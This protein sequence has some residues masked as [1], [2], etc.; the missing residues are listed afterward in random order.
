MYP[1]R[2]YSLRLVSLLASILIT[3]TGLYAA[4]KEY[5]VN[6]SATVSDTSPRITLSWTQQLQGNISAQRIYRR[7]KGETVWVKLADLTTTQTSYADTT[8]ASGVEY[9]YWLERTF[10]GTSPSPAIGYISA[11]VKVPEVH[12]RG[13]LLLV[14]D[15]TMVAPLAPE[16]AQLELDLAGD[17]WTVQQI[18]A[19]RSGTAISTKA[20]ITAA[21]NADPANVKMV[22]LLGHVPVPYSGNIGPDGHGDHVGAWP[23]DAYYGDMDDVWTDAT[24]NNTGASGTRNDNV[25]GDGKFD[26][27]NLPSLVELAVG[28]VDF[29]RINRAPSS[30]FSETARLRRYLRKAHDYRHKQGAYAAIPRRS[31]IRDGFGQFGS[32]AF[33]TTGW[34]VAYS[35]VG[36]SPGAPIDEPPSDQWFTPTYASGQ[37]YLWGYGCGGGSHESA[38]N[39]GNTTDF[40]HLASRAV[41]TSLFGSY[42]GD[43]DSDNNLMRSALAGNATG[44]SLALTCFWAGRPRYFMH[45]MGLGETVGFAAQTSMNAGLTGG[46]NYQPGGFSF[47]GTHLG[48]MGDPAL[49]VHQVTP[50]RRLAATTAS[51]QVNLSWAASG[52]TG[53]QGY[54]VYR[55]TS[56]G[57][58]FTKLN[59]LPV[60]ST[61]FTDA[62]VAAGTTY[63]YLVRT[64]RIEDAPGGTYHN[65]SIGSP[66]TITASAAGTGA[67]LSPSELRIVSQDSSISTQ[68]AWLDNASNETSYRVERKTNAGGTYATIGTL[69]VNVSTFTDTTA[70]TPGNVYYYRVIAVG[71]AG[72]SVPSNEV[73]FDAL[74]GFIEFTATRM[75]VDKLTGTAT[76]PVTRFGGGVGIVNVTYATANS[77][78]LAAQHYTSTN[79]TLTWADG[80]QGTKDITVSLIDSGT[81]QLPRQ[82]KVNLSS[83]TGGSA[84]AQWNSIAVLIEDSTATLAGP[85]QQTILGTITDSSPAVSAEGMIGDAT[86]GGNGMI[87]GATAEDGRF[88]YQNRSGDGVLT[89][90]VP[91]TVPLQSGAY[92]AVVVRASTANNALF[93]ATAVNNNAGANFGSKLSYRTT[94]GGSTVVT[95]AADNDLDTPRWIRISRAG[96]TFLSEAS[97]DGINWITLGSISLPSMP[98]NA[99]WGIFHRSNDLANST[100]YLGEFQLATYQNVTL[101]DLNTPPGIPTNLSAGGIAEFN[102]VPLMWNTP[103]LAFGY[104]IERRA[105][106]GGNF[107]QI[108]DIPAAGTYTDASVLP[109]TAYEYRIQAYNPVGQSAWSS[110][111]RLTTPKL[112]S[113]LNVTTKF[114]SGADTFI[115]AS[116]PDSGYST[117]ISLE[118]A[119]MVGGSVTTVSKAYFLFDLNLLPNTTFK[120]ASLKLSVLGSQSIGGGNFFFGNLVLLNSDQT[121]KWG[122]LGNLSTWNSTPQ[123]NTAGDDFL[124]PKL[125]LG[126]FFLSTAPT[127]GS[128]IASAITPA[129]LVGNQGAN[130]LVTLALRNSSANSSLTF[131]SRDHATEMPPTL[132]FTY[133]PLEPLRPGFVFATAGSGSSI[134]LAWHDSSGNENSFQLERRPL[135]GTYTVLAILPPNSTSYDDT[136]SQ[137]GVIYEYRLRAWNDFGGSTW[138]QLNNVVNGT[139]TAYQLWLQANGLPM[140]TTGGNAPGGSISGDGIPNMI[141]YA[142]GLAPDSDGY[143][144]HYIPGPITDGGEDYFSISYTRPEPEPAGLSYVIEVCTDPYAD[145]W[146]SIGL[147]EVSNN[148]G[149]GTRTIVIRDTVPMSTS[150]AHRFMRLKIVLP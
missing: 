46:G 13:K 122:K 72:N 128:V 140:D 86:I 85:W 143:A 147:V 31:I 38:D 149:A 141:K 124:S 44:D 32:E 119:G 111:L 2:S 23:A 150:P 48:L 41:F 68:L 148:V 63:T 123:N 54:H 77:S 27:S 138:V 114:G 106:D 137:S 132:E 80:E 144:G 83:P 133:V 95:P 43:W 67:P 34:A 65:L 84:L 57:G 16:I 100:T 134:S 9:E 36:Q 94:A 87:S 60:V 42:H 145:N 117:D 6:L 25:P 8:A 14:I 30:S 146:E 125:D 53:L 12:T 50:P 92:F 15:D 101:D 79:S 73:S 11:G 40:G 58:P 93:A 37:N 90:Y 56:P 52:E 64:V 59:T 61:A 107:V 28:R 5:V 70:V 104:R 66:I 130:K 135:N 35:V 75:K 127:P 88:I 139:P 98:A 17:G 121:D 102:R 76:I 1:N 33:A 131:A 103:G 81:P 116:T 10:S 97:A 89:A 120:T 71:A 110:P 20:L 18:V 136:T 26:Q 47:R 142:L 22:Y 24:V 55:G 39:F 7:L 21:Y 105:D 113:I 78:A 112:D 74:A 115:R 126:S 99:V 118:V 109:D 49:R 108:A 91:A 3:L 4:P 129:D 29:D 82:F 69:G 19:P 96:N 51:G 45:H 62:T